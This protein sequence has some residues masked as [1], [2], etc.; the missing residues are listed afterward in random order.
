MTLGK[1]VQGAA[2]SCFLAAKTWNKAQENP[3]A[4]QFYVSF[5]ILLSLTAILEMTRS[6]SHCSKQD[7][8]CELPFLSTSSLQSIYALMATY[9]Q[10]MPVEAEAR[11]FPFGECGGCFLMVNFLPFLCQRPFTSC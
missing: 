8:P 4:L 6:A 7:L 9:I 2:F 1:N 3:L 5:K 10:K 11:G